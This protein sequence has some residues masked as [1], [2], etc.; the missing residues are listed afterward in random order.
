MTATHATTEI[1]RA[2]AR[3]P[4]RVAFSI[5]EFCVRNDIGTGTYHKMKRLGLGPDEMRVGNLI[6]VTREAE[7]EMAAGPH[8]SGRRGGQGQG[9]IRSGNESARTESRQA[10]RGIAP[11]RL[12]AQAAERVIGHAPKAKP[13]PGW[14]Q[15]RGGLQC[16]SGR[17]SSFSL[18]AAKNKARPTG[19]SRRP[20]TS[21]QIEVV[22]HCTAVGV[23]TWHIVLTENASRKSVA[24]F[25]SKREAIEQLGLFS[26]KLRVRIV[27]R[28]SAVTQ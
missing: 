25:A 7:S 11:S 15:G 26:E 17:A 14:H 18:N 4:E 16:S 6:R 19:S 23:Q 5:G 22:H 3:Q 24:A 9:P 21:R 2:S 8:L 28:R 13:R 10:F 20:T 1:E 27:G 12:Q